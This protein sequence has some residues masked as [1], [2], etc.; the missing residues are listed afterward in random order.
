MFIDATIINIIITS[1]PPR[2][3][4]PSIN[5]LLVKNTC[6]NTPPLLSN[7]SFLNKYFIFFF[8]IY[9][10][11]RHGQ[12]KVFAK[13]LEIPLCGFESLFFRHFKFIYHYFPPDLSGGIIRPIHLSCGGGE[14]EEFNVII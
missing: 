7:N 6:V 5:N 2:G 10:K 12:D 9:R 14:L 11:S 8:N 4:G 13:S 1:G 3:A